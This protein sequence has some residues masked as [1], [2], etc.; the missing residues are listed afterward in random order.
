MDKA[1]AAMTYDE[2]EFNDEIEITYNGTKII[3]AE[4]R[5]RRPDRV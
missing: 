4:R 1:T 3:Q 5:P 2:F